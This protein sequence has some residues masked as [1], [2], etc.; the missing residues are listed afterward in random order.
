MVLWRKGLIAWQQDIKPAIAPAV[1]KAGVGFI[2]KCVHTA[3]LH[4]IYVHLY[5]YIVCLKTKRKRKML[6]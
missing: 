1:P 2:K 4:V 3:G 5:A 6:V